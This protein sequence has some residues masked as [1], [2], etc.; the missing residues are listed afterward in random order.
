MRRALK[1]HGCGNYL[2]ESG[3][4]RFVFVIQEKP[5]LGVAMAG[6]DCLTN[7]SFGQVVCFLVSRLQKPSV[8]HLEIN[9]AFRIGKNA[10]GVQLTSEIRFSPFPCYHWWCRAKHKR[11][12]K[13]NE[14][15]TKCDH[16]IKLWYFF[17]TGLCVSGFKHWR[18][19]VLLRRTAP[20]PALP[21]CCSQLRCGCLLRGA[22]LKD[23]DSSRN[24]G[25][26][27]KSI[28]KLH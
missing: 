25:K 2:P 13:F 3:L 12:M 28:E 6:R 20:R 8:S 5:K 11:S 27:V 4:A 19:F 22:F 18:K 24:C 21:S 15:F 7:S 26:S 14:S 23:E 1:L 9:E 17:S 10:D 16:V